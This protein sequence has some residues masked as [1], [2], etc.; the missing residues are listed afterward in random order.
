[1]KATLSPNIVEHANKKGLAG[2][3]IR[4][5]VTGSCCGSTVTTN[6]RFISADRVEKLRERGFQEFD[7]DGLKVMIDSSILVTDDISIEM[8]K[9]FG[10]KTFSIQGISLP[11]LTCRSC[12]PG[13]GA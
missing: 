10:V 7:A 5:R 2:L 8:A 11:G 12:R 4:L 3:E 13:Q 9:P 1:M 6:T